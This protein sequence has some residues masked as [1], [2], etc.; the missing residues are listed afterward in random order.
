MRRKRVKLTRKQS[1]VSSSDSS[2]SSLPRNSNK[3]KSSKIIKEVK[4]DY[5]VA[6]L[7]RTYYVNKSNGYKLVKAALDR[8]G[9]TQIPFEQSFF[10]KYGMKWVER[11][12]DIDYVAHISGQ[13]VCHI[14]NNEVITTK[15]SLV[16]TL[17]E[18]AAV[19][20]MA[21]SVGEERRGKV[22]WLPDTY[23]LACPED[24]LALLAMEDELIKERI[25]SAA[26]TLLPPYFYLF[27]VCV[28]M[29]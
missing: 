19:E 28:Q 29:T 13:L 21:H 20:N 24:V 9:W 23:Q 11:R 6:T 1:S 14:P 2:F 16:N 18:W 25:N 27:L 12:S 5:T 26:S 3:N 15:T 22:P 7:P 10:T 17:L 8:R 4:K